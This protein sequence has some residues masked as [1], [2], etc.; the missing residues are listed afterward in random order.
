MGS[1]FQVVVLSVL[2]CSPP[3]FMATASS[4]CCSLFTVRCS[5]FVVCCSL[6]VAGC[7]LL[8]VHGLCLCLLYA[9]CSGLSVCFLLVV[10]W[11]V[12]WFLGWFGKAPLNWMLNICR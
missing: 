7:L 11:S 4:V 5:S 2:F 1:G 9:V 6:V 12:G 8:V 10:G 3:S